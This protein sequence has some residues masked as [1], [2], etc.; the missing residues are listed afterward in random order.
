[1]NTLQRYLD[2]FGLNA[3]QI[4]EATGLG[5]H[6]VQKNI[7]GVRANPSVRKAIASYLGLP[8]QQVW[9]DDSFRV[10]GGLILDEII[11]QTEKERKRL[12][13]RYLSEAD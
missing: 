4:A 13:A 10:L 9:G 3:T 5:Y 12:L 6:S 1:M 2:L 8:C 11:N 7:K